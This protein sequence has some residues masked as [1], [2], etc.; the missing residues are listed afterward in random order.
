MKSIILIS[1]LALAV[2]AGGS[3]A[4]EDLPMLPRDVLWV[5]VFYQDPGSHE[6]G[7]GKEIARRLKPQ[8]FFRNFA[9]YKSR[10][11]SK[12]KKLI[13][14]AQSKIGKWVQD[15]ITYRGEPLVHARYFNPRMDGVYLGAEIP[16]D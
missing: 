7:S 15:Q 9:S 10:A 11:K 1:G 3:V 5:Y 13:I 14:T 2:F 4:S 12:N 6:R 16:L 8:E